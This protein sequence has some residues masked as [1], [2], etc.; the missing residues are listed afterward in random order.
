MCFHLVKCQKWSDA[1]AQ[2]C[3]ELQEFLMGWSA[4]S[5]VFCQDKHIYQ[6]AK[7]FPTGFKEI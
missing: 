6:N 4:L 1:T 3:T 2:K 7:L 5:V